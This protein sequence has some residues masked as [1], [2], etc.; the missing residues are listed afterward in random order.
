MSGALSTAIVSGTTPTGR[1]DVFYNGQFK[2]DPPA[3]TSSSTLSVIPD[4]GTGAILWVPGVSPRDICALVKIPKQPLPAAQLS[5]WTPT[6]I[7]SAV[8]IVG[9]S[10]APVFDRV[11]IGVGGDEV[12]AYVKDWRML[13]G[14]LQLQSHTTTMTSAVLSGEITGYAI[15]DPRALFQVRKYATVDWDSTTKATV[16]AAPDYQDT[17]TDAYLK[18]SSMNRSSIAEGNPLTRRIICRQLI[19]V[20]GA[21]QPDNSL[22][23]CTYTGVPTT[24]FALPGEL[25]GQGVPMPAGEVVPATYR[26]WIPFGT[27]AIW[28]Q[29]VFGTP[30][31]TPFAQIRIPGWTTPWAPPA[32]RFRGSIALPQNASVSNDPAA[33]GLRVTFYHYFVS[34]DP[35]TGVLTPQIVTDSQNIGEVTVTLPAA[36]A[37]VLD[38]DITSIP[39]PTEAAQLPAPPGSGTNMLNSRGLYWGTVI[40]FAATLARNGSGF[41]STN[42]S[43]SSGSISIES[44]AIPATANSA[45]RVILYTSIS[46]SSMMHITGGGM[47]EVD[48]SAQGAQLGG[49]TTVSNA[50]GFRT[51]PQEF[52]SLAQ[53]INA[54]VRGAP[55]RVTSA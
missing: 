34:Y 5:Q 35:T 49:T 3:N 13:G 23:G 38:V 27:C 52:L 55:K 39:H 51:N 31:T 48:W 50:E 16:I 54:S 53:V 40:V 20:A 12:G 2:T 6:G 14:K 33:I 10:V 21:L 45:T 30:L 11:S 29:N 22:F 8:D 36:P 46:A 41:A 37:G 24:E 18:R 25:I 43:I 44:A 7:F 47:V 26:D 32:V 4:A 19:D 1:L 15:S 28:A 9:P 42:M 17:M